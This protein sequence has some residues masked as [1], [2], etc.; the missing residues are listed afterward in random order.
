ML[1]IPADM[2]MMQHN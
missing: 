1:F 2:R